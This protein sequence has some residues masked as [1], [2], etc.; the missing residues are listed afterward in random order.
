MGMALLKNA[1]LTKNS[2]LFSV[3]EL[4]L[5]LVF[6]NFFYYLSMTA[7]FFLTS[8]WLQ[9]HPLYKLVVGMYHYDD[10]TRNT[11]SY[12]YLMPAAKGRKTKNVFDFLNLVIAQ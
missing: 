1:T 5:F 9:L 10:S 6:N 3:K 11:Q 8:L 12:K 7:K 4:I 2:H